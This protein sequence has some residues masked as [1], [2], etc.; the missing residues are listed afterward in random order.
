MSA[1][2]KYYECRTT[3]KE[4]DITD[5]MSGSA[6]FR[7]GDSSSETVPFRYCQLANG[8]YIIAMYDQRLTFI[9]RPCLTSDMTPASA[10]CVLQ[11]V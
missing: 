11:E 3:Y 8:K 2:A 5:C 7:E 10:M 6:S 9:I 4:S 1:I